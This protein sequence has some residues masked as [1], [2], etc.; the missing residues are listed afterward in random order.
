MRPCMITDIR[1]VGL[2]DRWTG[3]AALLENTRLPTYTV[4]S[5]DW[6]CGS[7]VHEQNI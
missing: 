1:E 4:L 2:V 7:S 3:E 6:A 5:K